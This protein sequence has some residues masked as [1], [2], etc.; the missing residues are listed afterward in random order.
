VIQPSDGPGTIY[1]ADDPEEFWAKAGPHLLHEATEY[2]SWQAGVKSAVHDRSQTVEEMKAA[3]VYA[4]MT[5]DELI[6]YAASKPPLDGVTTHPLCGGMPED[7]SWSSLEL[8]ANTVIPAVRAD[9][10]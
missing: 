6:E 4:V 5:P 1:C 10:G 3:G 9:Q 7:L 2:S 8:M